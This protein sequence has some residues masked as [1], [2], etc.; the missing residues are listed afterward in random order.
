MNKVKIFSIGTI[1]A[2]VVIGIYAFRPLPD[3]RIFKKATNSNAV[4]PAASIPG[5]Q[6]PVDYKIPLASSETKALK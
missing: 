4:T 6:F 2:F 5:Y 1:T 3:E